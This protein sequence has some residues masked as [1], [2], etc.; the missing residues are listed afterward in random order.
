MSSSE[1]EHTESALP[2]SASDGLRELS[3]KKTLVPVKVLA[4]FASANL[5]LLKQGLLG[6]PYSHARKLKRIV[7][8]GIPDDDIAVEAVVAVAVDRRPV[9]VVRRSSAVH[10]PV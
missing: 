6:D 3:C 1:K 2:Y 5:K 7:S 4:L 9:I 10:N 8:D